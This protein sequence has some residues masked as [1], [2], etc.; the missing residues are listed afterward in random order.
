MIENKLHNIKG[1]SHYRIIYNGSANI[2]PKGYKGISHLIEHCM[3]EKIK[4][5]EQEFK[6]KAIS[7]NACTSSNKVWF[8]ISGMSKY[9]RTFINEY[10]NAI[11]NYQ[12]SEEVFNREK[13]IVI[14]EYFQS[15]SDQTNAFILNFNRKHYNNCE[16]IGYIEDLK[17][18][19]YENFMSYKNKIFNKPS[20]I[21]Y[22]HHK[23]EKN[24]SK[25]DLFSIDFNNIKEYTNN[26]IYDTYNE[27]PIETYATFDNQR[28]IALNTN[29]T[30]DK[31][32]KNITYANLFKACILKG[33]T[34][35]LYIE[36]R[37]K[38][39]CV[40]SLYGDVNKIDNNTFSFNIFV[41]TTEE[42][43]NIVLNKLK[44]II[45]NIKKYINKDL[46]KRNV[47]LYKNSHKISDLINWDN[48]SSELDEQCKNLILKNKINYKDFLQYIDTFLNSD[49]KYVIDEQYIKK[50]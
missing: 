38:L 47:S 11:L 42:G 13:N 23:S 7:W 34:S 25:D 46:Y 41:F 29:L 43:K 6:E 37:E 10:T 49:I 14:T 24:L 15:Y 3:C 45:V 5:F 26:M 48:V 27:Y 8:Y 40:Y 22:V 4:E 30:L 2:E 35:P 31:E 32:C 16:A 17:N 1:V 18:L 28:I 12:I 50:D 44:E 21:I 9:I 33:L 36:L 19:T 20:K 39:Q